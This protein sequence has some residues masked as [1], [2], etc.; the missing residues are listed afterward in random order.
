VQLHGEGQSTRQRF[1]AIQESQYGRDAIYF[2]PIFDV[3]AR[4]AA[5]YRLRILL[6]Y[7]PG[8][9]IL[10]VGP[11]TGL[12]LSLAARRGFSC[13]AV[14][15]SPVM[16]GAV[17]A[18]TS[19]PVHR[20]AFE[21]LDLAGSQ[22]DAYVSFHVLEHVVDPLEHL[23]TALRVVRPGGY[24][25]VTTPNAGSLEHRLT[26]RNSP[27]YSRAHVR[28]FSPRSLRTVCERAGW[29]VCDMSNRA[30]SE[31]WLRVLTALSR[32]ARPSPHGSCE[33]QRDGGPV[34]RAVPFLVGAMALWTAEILTWPP[35]RLQRR[36]SLGNER[37]VVARKP[38]SPRPAG[39]AR[40]TFTVT[41]PVSTTP[42]G[43]LPNR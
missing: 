2:L 5:R 19:I 28:L 6:R 14:E 35:R 33:A 15:F 16:A 41:A 9:H 4:R 40:A 20:G 37:I 27:N 12:F 36:L 25:L 1:E 22:F 42:V 30:R 17:A 26:R 39:V 21:D 11:G 7:L 10:E 8:G 3:L 18:S 43:P 13:E 34:L 29:Q 38:M 24:A 31:D 32:R 23:R